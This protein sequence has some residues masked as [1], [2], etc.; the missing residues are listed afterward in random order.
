MDD[1]LHN[2]EHSQPTEA[3]EHR[4][5]QS[6]TAATSEATRPSPYCNGHL[7]ITFNQTIYGTHYPSTS[8]SSTTER[9]RSRSLGDKSLPLFSIPSA[10]ISVYYNK[11]HLLGTRY[12]VLLRGTRSHRAVSCSSSVVKRLHRVP[13]RHHVL[14]KPRRVVAVVVVE[15]RLRRSQRKEE[16]GQ[17]LVKGNRRSG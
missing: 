17:T 1:S 14:L 15:S 13:R 6:H 11:S 3:S 12:P 9:T 16:Q 5:I 7:Q 4:R 2:Y 10:S 8:H